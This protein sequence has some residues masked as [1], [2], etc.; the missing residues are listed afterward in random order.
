VTLCTNLGRKVD[1]VTWLG[2]D[3]LV[4]GGTVTYWADGG[5]PVDHDK[6]AGA[7]LARDTGKVLWQF[8]SFVRNDFFTLAG[9][10]DGRCLAILDI[11]GQP[12]AGFL[13][14]GATGEVLQ[15]C[16]D[17]AHGSGPLS[18][19]I[20]PDGNT[21]AVGYAPWDVILW[22]ARTG[23]RQALL[24]GHENW[25]V[26]LAF[27]TDSKRLISGAG[28]STA[29]VWDMERGKEIGRIRFQGGS[30]YVNSVGL[31]PK[32]DIVF[33]LAEGMLVVAEG[34]PQ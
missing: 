32:G 23:K 20:S 15:T 19:G 27:S 14:D 6:P 16:Y 4:W 30:T 17:R 28:D 22:E 24:K 2:N 33:A 26:S 1:R 31:S 29:R 3:R 21:L 8:R 25:V 12:R 9:A 13:L 7:V 5:K 11:P 18:V 10:R 34:P